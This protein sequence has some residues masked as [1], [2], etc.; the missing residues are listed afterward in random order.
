MFVIL[1][2]YLVIM[3]TCEVMQKDDTKCDTLHHMWQ[4]LTLTDQK[5]IQAER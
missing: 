4:V 2:F 1:F 3:P 5:G